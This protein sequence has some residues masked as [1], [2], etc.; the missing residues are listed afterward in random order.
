MLTN[1]EVNIRDPYVLVHEGRYYLYGT[2]SA[3]AWGHADGFDCYVSDDLAHWEGPLEVFHNG[4]DFWAD[5]C[6]WAPECYAQDGEFYLAATFRSSERTLGIQMLHAQ[7]P[8]GPFLPMGDGPITPADFTCL[9]GTLFFAQGEPWLVFSQSMEQDSRGNMCAMPLTRDLRAAAGEIR[10][11]FQAEDAPWTAPFPYAKEEFGR[12]EAMYL[13]D[14]PALYQT[15]GGKLVMLWS[16]FGPEGYTVGQSVS[17]NGRLDGGWQHMPEPL[18]KGDG[19]HGMLFHRP[20][21]QLIYTLHSP[22]TKGEEHPIFL[23]MRDAGD[24]LVVEAHNGFEG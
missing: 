10:V 18:L 4:G 12:N 5:R 6:Y 14:G 24:R 1:R 11:L 21:G 15:D 22:N 3:T 19:G 8:I 7:S 9:D 17:G 20:G 23:P 16:S 2:R 13:S